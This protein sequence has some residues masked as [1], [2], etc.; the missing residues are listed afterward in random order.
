MMAYLTGYQ[1]ANKV[2]NAN[3]MLTLK[4]WQTA[5]VNEMALVRG[6]PQSLATDTLGATKFNVAN[7]TTTLA[8]VPDNGIVDRLNKTVWRKDIV[9]NVV[10]SSLDKATQDNA[11]NGWK[12]ASF[13]DHVNLHNKGPGGTYRS[14]ASV[15]MDAKAD[16]A[17][18]TF[19]TGDRSADTVFKNLQVGSYSVGPKAGTF[20]T[21]QEIN[22]SP[23]FYANS[24]LAPFL[25]KYSSNT[26]GFGGG[27]GGFGGMIGGSLNKQLLEGRAFTPAAINIPVNSGAGSKEFPSLREVSPDE[28]KRRMVRLA[29]VLTDANRTTFGADTQYDMM[30]PYPYH[31]GQ[32]W[33]TG[34][35]LA[36]VKNLTDAE[37]ARLPVRSN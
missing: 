6:V 26:G 36:M 5:R 27:F 3:I 12:V 31:M 35:Y 18:A 11:V 9:S 23:G 2:D 21:L 4:Q 33:S 30:P 15:G 13:Q 8:S 34:L 32:V 24:D 14:F 1:T 25:A 19:W 28:V 10:W 20:T 29:Y 16:A 22:S 7:V 37:A 17:N